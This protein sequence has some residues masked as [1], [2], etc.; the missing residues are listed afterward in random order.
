MDIRNHLD[1]AADEIDSAGTL[2][3][4]LLDSRPTDPKTRAILRRIAA[5]LENADIT[6]ASIPEH[7]AVAA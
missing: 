2:L 4:Q 3:Q 6:L 5:H 1:I 7:L